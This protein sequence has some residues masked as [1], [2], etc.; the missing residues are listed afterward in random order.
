MGEYDL[1]CIG[2]APNGEAMTKAILGTG[3]KGTVQSRTFRAFTE[4]EFRKLVGELG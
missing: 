3:A 1:V 4:T 2:E